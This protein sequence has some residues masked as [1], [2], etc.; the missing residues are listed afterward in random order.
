MPDYVDTMAY[1]NEKPWHGLGENVEDTIRVRDMVKKAKILWKVEKRPLTLEGGQPVPGFFALVR[2]DNN[3]VLDVVGKAYQVTQNAD[4]MEFFTEFVEAGDAKMSTMGSLREGR[5]VWGLASLGKDIKL[6][7]KDVIKNNLLLVLP[8]E[9]GKGIISK[10]CNE[11]VVCSNTMAIA[12][13]E[14]GAPEFRMGHRKVFGKAEM[15][16]AKTVLGIAREKA[17]EFKEAANIL[18]DKTGITEQDKLKFFAE[19]LKVDEAAESLEQVSRPRIKL[20]MDI[21]VRAPGAIPGSA[22]GL[23]NA[24]TYYADHM[25][26]R[27][28]DKRLANAWMGKTAR[29]KDRALDLLLAA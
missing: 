7:N 23:F 8:H 9:H 27:T 22:W 21:S 15:Q 12:L 5:Q 14:S 4:A 24:V 19:V 17:D 13:R 11:R 6:K 10:Y 18:I 2:D 25:A 20:L 26:S 16:Q 29:M 3:F 28:A 1:T